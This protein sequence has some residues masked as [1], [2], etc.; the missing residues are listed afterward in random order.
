MDNALLMLDMI[1]VQL[2]AQLTL[3]LRTSFHGIEWTN[4]WTRVAPDTDV[5]CAACTLV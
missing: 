4:Y 1:S 3:P 2:R 5:V